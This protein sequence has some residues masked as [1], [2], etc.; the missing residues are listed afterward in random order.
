MSYPGHGYGAPQGFRPQAA[1]VAA[2]S[3]AQ[4]QSSFHF[5]RGPNHI[6]GELGGSLIPG[7]GLG[8]VPSGPTQTPQPLAVPAT[9]P[10][11]QA[12]LSAAEPGTAVRLPGNA[13]DSGSEEGEVSDG[14]VEDLYEPLEANHG[15]KN[16]GIS[17]RLSGDAG[18]DK[19]LLTTEQQRQYKMPFEL[20]RE[21]PRERSGSYSPHLSPREID[22]ADSPPS[23]IHLGM[24]AP[25]LI[26]YF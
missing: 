6:Q 3:F 1:R 12:A 15:D 21:V 8:V 7:L 2:P 16:A 11:T 18:V 23:T 19:S 5:P 22:R 24:H 4:A 10:S 20:R 26:L 14:E 13:T 17:G 25:K 9:S